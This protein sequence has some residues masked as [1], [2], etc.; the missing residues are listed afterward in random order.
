M[1]LRDDQAR[2]RERWPD[3][4]DE[5]DPWRG[6]WRVVLADRRLIA[7]GPTRATAWR[8]AASYA[9]DPASEPV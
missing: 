8:H 2:T 7:G 5:H 1:A 4:C 9:R 3:A 6:R